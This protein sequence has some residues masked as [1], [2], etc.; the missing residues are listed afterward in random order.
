MAAWWLGL[1]WRRLALA[2]LDNGGLVARASLAKAGAGDGSEA[3]AVARKL[4][5]GGSEALAVARKLALGGS[6]AMGS[7]SGWRML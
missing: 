5:L 7:G 1:A 3:L 6:G 4:A 2:V